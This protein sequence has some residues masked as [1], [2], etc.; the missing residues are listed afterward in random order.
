MT[1]ICIV[2]SDLKNEHF[3]AIIPYNFRH[4]LSRQECIDEARHLTYREIEASLGICPTCIHS[5]LHEHLEVKKI[6][7]RWIPKSLKKARV[8]W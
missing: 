4:E 5:I 2:Y 8:D 6:C 7:S 3:R 1:V